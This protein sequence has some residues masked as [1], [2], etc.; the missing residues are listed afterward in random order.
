MVKDPSSPPATMVLFPDLL[1]PEIISARSN[2]AVDSAKPAAVWGAADA[3]RAV[4]VPQDPGAH[5]R[6]FS[7]LDLAVAAAS[8]AAAAA[9]EAANFGELDR[10]PPIQPSASTTG[11]G[12][13]G[14]GAGDET[15]WSLGAGTVAGMDRPSLIV[16]AVANA[17][18]C[19]RD[20]VTGA[21][22]VSHGMDL[23]YK[24]ETATSP[25]S[26]AANATGAAGLGAHWRSS[27]GGDLSVP[28]MNDRA[29]ELAGKR[30][31]GD[32]MVVLVDGGTEHGAAGS[33]SVDGDTSQ[34]DG[35]R[36]GFLA[37]RLCLGGRGGC[38]LCAR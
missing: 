3:M 10:Y 18:G 14:S 4:I 13:G 5:V 31:V 7:T 37:L 6:A 32:A 30:V 34:A 38:V 2:L 35:E 12:G 17:L 19:D 36:R 16:E 28:M 24:Q 9:E 20:K 26:A 8:I 29:S 15:G 33:G 25:G 23:F 11:E 22:M 21:G 27:G 1:P